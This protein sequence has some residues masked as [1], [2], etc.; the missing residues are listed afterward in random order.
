MTEYQSFFSLAR[1]QAARR[2]GLGVLTLVCLIS[3]IAPFLQAQK[4]EKSARRVI[5]M[6]RPN[7]PE[8]LKTHH[9]EGLVRLKVTVSAT[10][11][12]GD[13]K[14]VGGNPILVENGIRAVQ[15]WKYVPAASQTEEDVVLSFVSR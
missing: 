4:S 7:Y 15:S 14:I 9:I 3:S 8:A 11:A 10:G 5:F 6:V 12:V 1:N 2:C 13:I